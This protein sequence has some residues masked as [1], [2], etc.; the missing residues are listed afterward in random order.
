M[1][2]TTREFVNVPLASLVDYAVNN[3]ISHILESLRTDKTLKISSK[4]WR[5][6]TIRN[7]K[8]ARVYY[9]KINGENVNVR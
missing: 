5:L 6:R 3:L 9:T 8:K 1:M 4:L 7:P 2:K